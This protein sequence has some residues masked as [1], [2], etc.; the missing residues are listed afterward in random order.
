MLPG[1]NDDNAEMERMAGFLGGLEG[2]R[3]VELLPLHHL[4]AAKYESLGRAYTARGLEPLSAASMTRLADLF[5]Q[6]GLD[7]RSMA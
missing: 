1:F 5:V 7:A 3:R 6:H 2:V 4:G